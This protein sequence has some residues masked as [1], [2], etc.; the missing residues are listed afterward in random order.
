MITTCPRNHEPLSNYYA[1]LGVSTTAGPAGLLHAYRAAVKKDHPDAGGDPT[2]RKVRAVIEAYSV[3][4]D[5]QKRRRYDWLR[6]G[7][8]VR[9]GYSRGIRAA[10]HRRRHRRYRRYRALLRFLRGVAVTACVVAGT[11]LFAAA[12]AGVAE[13]P[14]RNEGAGVR[15]TRQLD[16]QDRARSDQ[17]GAL[18]H[19]RPSA[20]YC[21]RG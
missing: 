12:V 5:P 14:R 17:P 16:P 18:A 6:T 4:K 9:M 8:R 20:R 21:P 10:H 15:R 2:G 3:L 13:A 1:V 7:C 19:N 11:L